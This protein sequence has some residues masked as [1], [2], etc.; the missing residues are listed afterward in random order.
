MAPLLHKMRRILRHSRFE[1]ADAHDTFPENYI[2]GILFLFKLI[3]F[4]YIF[5]NALFDQKVLKFYK[6]SSYQ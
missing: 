3:A 1:D 5:L 6:P 4:P 2:G